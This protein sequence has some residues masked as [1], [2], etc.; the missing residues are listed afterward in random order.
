[1]EGYWSLL[2][3]CVSLIIGFGGIATIFV[4]GWVK[5]IDLAKLEKEADKLRDEID[6]LWEKVT[7]IE[8]LNTKLDNIEKNVDEIKELIKDQKRD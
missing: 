2:T 1:M 4:N 7:R 6:K 8:I 5:T 3:V